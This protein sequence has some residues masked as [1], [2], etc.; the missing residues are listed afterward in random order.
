TRAASRERG[1]RRRS[2]GAGQTEAAW[3]ARAAPRLMQAHAL[4]HL[5]WMAVSKASNSDRAE[6]ERLAAQTA[7]FT[8]KVRQAFLDAIDQIGNSVDTKRVADLLRQGRVSEAIEVVSVAAI[9]AGL[10]PVAAAV[11]DVLIAAGRAAPIPA[12]GQAQ[13]VFGA[14]SPRT[15]AY[16]QQYEFG[17]IRDLTAE[18]RRA[19]GQIIADGVTNGINPNDIARDVRAHIGLTQWQSEAVSNYRRALENADRAALQRALRDRRFDS[20][21]ARA[22][23]GEKALSPEQIDKM[24]DR[25]RQRYLTY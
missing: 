7:Q 8:A 24:V 3:R 14:M 25:Y 23:R 19:I 22:A 2:I 4:A 10:K 20:S 17:L 1:G 11:T 15:V 16:L 13:F 9:A 12:L 6:I 21:V 18:A 5:P